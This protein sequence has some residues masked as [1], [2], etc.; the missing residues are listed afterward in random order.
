MVEE[1]YPLV[2][3]FCT[4]RLNSLIVFVASAAPGRDCRTAA[5]GRDRRSGH[6]PYLVYIW[7]N[8]FITNICIGH[9][10]IL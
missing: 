9:L 5:R 2:D 4:V 3:C 6:R 1:G 7:W 10:L 8:C